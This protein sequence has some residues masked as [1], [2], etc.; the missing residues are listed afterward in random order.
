ML[1]IKPDTDVTAPQ[2][3]ADI[4][5]YLALKAIPVPSCRANR[6]QVGRAGMVIA[7]GAQKEFFPGE[8]RARS[9]VGHDGGNL[10]D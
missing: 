2:A 8:S 1:N 7:K 3:L 5:S 9:A 4:D 10:G 6:V